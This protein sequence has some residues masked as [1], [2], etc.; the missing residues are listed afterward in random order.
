MEASIHVAFILY[1]KLCSPDKRLRGERLASSLLLDGFAGIRKQWLWSGE[2][3]S[4]KQLE[5]QR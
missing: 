5:L 3:I 4:S 1:Y 2:A